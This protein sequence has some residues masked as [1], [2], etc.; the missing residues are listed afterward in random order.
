LE[1]TGPGRVNPQ[2]VEL[3]PPPGASFRRCAGSSSG[4]NGPRIRIRAAALLRDLD[5]SAGG[6][7]RVAARAEVALI[8]RALEGTAGG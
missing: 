7:V 8:D 3:R 4:T 2:L 5:R 1:A 6:F